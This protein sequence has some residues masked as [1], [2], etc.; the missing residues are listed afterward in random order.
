MK[1]MNFYSVFIMD[2]VK[3]LSLFDL[4]RKKPAPSGIKEKIDLQLKHSWQVARK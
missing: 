4:K 1:L 2:I 3:F